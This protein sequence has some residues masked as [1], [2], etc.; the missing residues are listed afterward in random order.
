M[1]LW[2]NVIR[3]TVD[4]AHRLGMLARI[5]VDY[6]ITAQAIQVPATVEHD[7]NDCRASGRIVPC[8]VS[9]APELAVKLIQPRQCSPVAPN[10]YHEGHSAAYDARRD[11]FESRE[12][13]EVSQSAP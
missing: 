1:R 7:R 6:P 2:A 11:L 3:L 13:Q 10:R 12:P 5:E 9:L 4:Y 8:V